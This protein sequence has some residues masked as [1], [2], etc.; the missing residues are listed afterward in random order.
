MQVQRGIQRG[1]LRRYEINTIVLNVYC[2]SKH[3]MTGPSGN[4]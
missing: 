3:L 2:D 1:K 4:S